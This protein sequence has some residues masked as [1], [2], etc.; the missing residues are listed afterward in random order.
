MRQ[1]LAIILTQRSG[2][3]ESD[4]L[5]KRTAYPINP[6]RVEYQLTT[7][8]RNL[9]AA[10]C[11]VWLWAEAHHDEINPARQAFREHAAVARR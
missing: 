9:S 5:V 3:E 2:A 1:F 7:L 10:F 11:G 4:G 8:G 6:P